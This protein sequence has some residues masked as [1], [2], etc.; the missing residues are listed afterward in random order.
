MQNPYEFIVQDL[1]VLS[2][3]AD[4]GLVRVLH[5]KEC[6]NS[7]SQNNDVLDRSLS[8]FKFVNTDDRTVVYKDYVFS[9]QQ[10]NNKQISCVFFLL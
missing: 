10:F 8:S 4:K 9:G 7:L 5:C 6:E 1:K 2:K 3:F